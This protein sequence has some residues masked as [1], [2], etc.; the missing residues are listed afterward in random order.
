MRLLKTIFLA[1]LVYLGPVAQAQRYPYSGEYLGWIRMVD[2]NAAEKPYT[3]DHRKYSVRQMEISRMIV[4]WLQQ[5]YTP[6][7]AIGQ[8]F[9]LVND[10]IGTNN[11]NTTS[12]PQ[13]YGATTKTFIELRK[14]NENKWMPYTNT[15]WFMQVAVNGW[16]GNTV[17]LISTPE[18]YYFYIPGDE[19]TQAH[20]EE[21]E[22][23]LGFSSHPAL[24][25][26]I[27]WFQ[28]KTPQ[29]TLQ[30]VVLLCKNNQKPYVQ[31]TKG[32][33]LDELGKAIDK[34][35]RENYTWIKEEKAKNSKYDASN[36]EN[37]LKKRK[38][39]FILLREKYKNRLQ[40]PAKISGFPSLNI[41]NESGF[42]V[43]ENPNYPAV[44]P[45][46]KFNPDLLKQTSS[47]VPQW[48]VISWDAEGVATQEEA[49]VHLHRS[50]LENIDYNYIYNYFFE[51][52]KIKGT[53]Y[54]PRRSPN[55]EEKTLALEKSATASK[56]AADG[57]IV[58][59]EDFS[60][61]P[62]GKAP[63]GWRSSYNA[64][65]QRALVKKMEGSNDHWVELKGQ[66]LYSESNG[67]ALPE[68]FKASFDVAVKKGFKWGTPALECYLAGSKK[69]D[70]VY[71]HYI[72]VQ[73]K[74]GFDER[75]GWATV[76]VKSP[77]R[78]FFPPEVAVPGFS[79]NKTLNKTTVRIEKSGERIQVFV[80]ST[81]VFDEAKAFPK[82]LTLDQVFFK[83]IHQGWDVEEFYITNI[84]ISK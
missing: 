17:N 41:E 40:E 32:E 61:T 13:C 60:A 50:M 76:N 59:F 3:V 15:N 51:P 35:A 79:N 64:S 23:L 52:A 45:I 26:Y 36:T 46:Y 25:P 34:D 7:G 11:T 80:G 67:R 1:V 78:S 77:E 16:I 14:N 53:A 70:E 82:G 10:K 74:P 24:K 27:H 63:L 57:S 83:E 38:E 49:G 18:K 81:K 12:A 8:A 43:F 30:Y 37:Q 42:D 33:Y 84:R 58:L 19:D 20:Q 71:G 29:T 4:G 5:S 2:P 69:S 22:N 48:I 21:L 66:N 9:K 6:K 54:K 47:D 39:A 31:I 28:P 75:D 68:N 44:Y 65:V 73:V 72:T 62:E 56:A 55:F